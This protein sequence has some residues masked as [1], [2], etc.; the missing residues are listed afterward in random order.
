VVKFLPEIKAIEKGK[1]KALK[2]KEI[3]K[4][5]KVRKWV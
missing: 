1:L 2:G 3:E 5:L 4:F